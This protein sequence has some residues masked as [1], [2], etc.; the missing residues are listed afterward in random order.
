[1]CSLLCLDK[2]ARLVDT[3]QKDHKEGEKHKAAPYWLLISIWEVKEKVTG[4]NRKHLLLYGNT[5]QVNN[6][7]SSLNNSW[8][9]L[10]I[11]DWWYQTVS[12]YLLCSVLFI[13]EQT[14]HPEIR[15]K[16]CMLDGKK[17]ILLFNIRTQLD[18]VIH[19]GRSLMK[20]KICHPV[21]FFF[22]E[23]ARIWSEA[24]LAGA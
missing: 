15:S 2:V 17:Y 13:T 20:S 1:M 7:T 4:K 22:K 11:I 10:N 5:R 14:E 21:I 23:I 24:H 19:L 18:S 12:E 6:N 16:K 3:S 9:P 8:N